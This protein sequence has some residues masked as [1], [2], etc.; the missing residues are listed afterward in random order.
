MTRARSP[1]TGPLVNI[2]SSNA[3]PHPGE[4]RA[5]AVAFI[6]GMGNIASIV[7][8]FKRSLSSHAR[9]NSPITFP[10]TSNSMAPSCSQKFLPTTTGLALEFYWGS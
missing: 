10:P 6:N 7:S 8:T 1:S 3:I 4:K 5:V 9:P 2:W